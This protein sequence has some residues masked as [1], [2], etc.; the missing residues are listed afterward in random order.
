MEQKKPR[1]PTSPP[2]SNETVDIPPVFFWW[3]H[4][5]KTHFRKKELSKKKKKPLVL[6]QKMYFHE[7]DQSK[8]VVFEPKSAL[9]V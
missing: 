8:K 5:I 7:L 1:F 3:I 2:Y 9:L 6:G 4:I